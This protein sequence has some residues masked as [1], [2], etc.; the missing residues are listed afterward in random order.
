MVAILFK[1][2]FCVISMISNIITRLI[3]ST[4]AYLI[5]LLIHALKVPGEATKGILE[6]AA[7]ALR[8]AL[9]Y[10]LGTIMEVISTSISSIIHAIKDGII[11][12][13]VNGKSA[14][15]ELVDQ[16]KSSFEGLLKDVVP[17]I[18]Q[19]F[20]EMATNIV[21]DLWNNYIEAIG[22]FKSGEREAK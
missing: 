15:A 10:M 7:G 8:S 17:E 14:L 22:G 4:T 3:F 21:S 5:V 13:I 6:Q 19:G 9:E 20:S 2:I 11:E 1:L 16:T 12:S 18:V